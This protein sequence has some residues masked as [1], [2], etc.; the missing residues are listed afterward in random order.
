MQ[1]KAGIVFAAAVLMFLL[2]S[3]GLLFN[4]FYFRG[5]VMSLRLKSIVS[6]SILFVSVLS[7]PLCFGM[8]QVEQD[9]CQTITLEC[10][11]G[12]L[13][14]RFCYIVKKL[15]E[16][17]TALKMEKPLPQ[18]ICEN[19]L[20][21][22]GPPGNGKTTIAKKIAEM[23]GVHY[24]YKNTPELVNKF[25][26]G[27]TANVKKLFA[28]ARAHADLYHQPVV[29]IMDEIDAMAD[30]EQKAELLAALQELWHQLDLIQNDPRFFFIGMTNV[31][32]LHPTF[33]S[34]F[35]ES[36]KKIKAPKAQVRTAVLQYYKKKY[37]GEAWNEK[38]LRELVDNSGGGKLSI[39][40]LEFYVRRVCM[41]AENENAGVITDELARK[42]FYKMKA[43]YVETFSKWSARQAKAHWRELL[44]LAR[45]VPQLIAS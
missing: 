23:A 4:Y 29:I 25:Y 3:R 26:G 21:L 33:K 1:V 43:K 15:K 2:N 28:E 8:V 31:E 16:V 9:S 27:S 44:Y 39:R 19:R 41:V 5:H 20:L 35:G 17:D 18:V 37:T 38:I 14:K 45:A 12:K 40:F 7:S 24:I 32:E 36:I 34:R 13:S 11:V 22:Y 10:F 42:V 30:K 6:I